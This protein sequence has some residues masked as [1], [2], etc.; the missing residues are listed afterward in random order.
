MTTIPFV[1]HEVAG[2]RLRNCSRKDFAHERIIQTTDYFLNDPPVYSPSLYMDSMAIESWIVKTEEHMEA[3]SIDCQGFKWSD[4]LIGSDAREIHNLASM[5]TFEEEC[6]SDSSLS[7]DSHCQPV[8]EPNLKTVD[9]GTHDIQLNTDADAQYITIPY[10]SPWYRPPMPYT[11]SESRTAADDYTGTFPPSCSCDVQ[12]ALTQQVFL[13]DLFHEELRR[14]IP[15]YGGAD[16]YD[17]IWLDDVDAELLLA[18]TEAFEDICWNSAVAS[19]PKH[20]P[21]KWK[22]KPLP[23]VPLDFGDDFNLY[24]I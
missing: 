23:D 4:E 7:D 11:S 16:K 9:R 22:W 19:S 21:P 12:Q 10:D 20:D 3:L 8:S 18:P 15:P 1:G 2:Q 17:T 5:H 6:D 24:Q 13:L 14:S